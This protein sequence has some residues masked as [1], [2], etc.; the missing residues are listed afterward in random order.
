M[1]QTFVKLLVLLILLLALVSCSGTAPT[2]T[3]APAPTETFI[4]SA[5]LPAPPAPTATATQALTP[6]PHPARAFAEPIL[7]ALA[8]VKPYFAD[9]FSINRGWAQRFDGQLQVKAGVVQATGSGGMFL[10]P[11][12]DSFS[13]KDF[14]LALDVRLLNAGTQFGAIFRQRYSQPVSYAFYLRPSGNWVFE[15]VERKGNGDAAPTYIEREIAAG[16][17]ANLRPGQ[18]NHLVIL[19]RGKRFAAYLN[20]LPMM[21]A[22][23]SAQPQAGLCIDLGFEGGAQGAAGEFDNLQFWDLAQTPGLP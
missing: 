11:H 14:V 7:A 3:A 13:Q 16:V 8:Q 4:P 1:P 2:P 9:D 22:E 6:T 5:S 12:A 23:D 17:A 18:P 21:Y 10:P 20:A 15:S 19:A